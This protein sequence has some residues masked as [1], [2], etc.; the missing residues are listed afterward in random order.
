MIKI[1][2]CRVFFTATVGISQK[3]GRSSPETTGYKEDQFSCLPNFL[4]KLET[5]TKTRR[6]GRYVY[7][8]LKEDKL[9]MENC[10]EKIGPEL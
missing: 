6:V 1:F 7:H 10:K 5:P 8:T 3:I 2:P 9:I 4:K